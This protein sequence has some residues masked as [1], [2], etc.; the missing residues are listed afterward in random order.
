MT[1]SFKTRW[2]RAKINQVTAAQDDDSVG[3]PKN[4][5]KQASAYETA[6]WEIFIRPSGTDS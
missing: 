4:T 3:G 1:I 6:S 2:L 5:L